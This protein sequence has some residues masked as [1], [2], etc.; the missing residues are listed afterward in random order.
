VLQLSRIDR[1]LRA[2]LGL[3]DSLSVPVTLTGSITLNP[4]DALSPNEDAFRNPL[5]SPLAIYELKWSIVVPGTAAQDTT[6]SGGAVSVSLALGDKP[7]T[8]SPVLL[9]NLG[10]T[11]DP[12]GENIVSKATVSGQTA[13]TGTFGWQ[14]MGSWRLDEP[15]YLQ[16]GEQLSAQ[17]THMGL[18]SNPLTVTVSISGCVVRGLPDR[19]MLPY[20]ASFIA[21]AMDLSNGVAGASVSS[22]EKDLANGSGSILSVRRLI[23]RL[24]QF[25]TGTKFLPAANLTNPAFAGVSADGGP[26]LRDEAI[27]LTLRNSQGL[28]VVG[29]AVGI[30]FGAAFATPFNSLEIHHKLNPGEYYLATLTLSEDIG[31]I[32][33][34][35][36]ALTSISMI[37]YREVP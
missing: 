10:R 9:Q 21:P 18:T 6:L 14:A 30:P 37:G 15:F 19:K 25:N 16:P 24:G 17:L 36:Q 7:I 22:T 32:S 5:Q 28:P 20:I 26:S 29:G 13:T 33:W 23:G 2:A 34:S 1:G 31:P 3:L 27:L 8:K 35:L 12:L 11:T 4:G